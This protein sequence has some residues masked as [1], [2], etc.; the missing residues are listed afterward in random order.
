M[1]TSTVTVSSGLMPKVATAQVV[2]SGLIPKVAAAQMAPVPLSAVPPVYLLNLNHLL[3]STDENF[4][5]GWHSFVLESLI[6]FK[7]KLNMYGDCT[8]THVHFPS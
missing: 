5:F 1:S 8:F 2:P 3:V 6:R 7:K 4:Q